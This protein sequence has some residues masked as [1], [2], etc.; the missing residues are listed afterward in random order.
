VLRLAK[1]SVLGVLCT[2]VISAATAGGADKP[3][4]PPTPAPP[5]KADL[6]GDKLFEDLES[7]L[8]TMADS[9]SLRVIVLLRQ[10][11][12][13]GAVD[14]L[15][16]SVGSFSLRHRYSIVPGFAATATKA[17]VEKLAR[18]PIV[19]QVEEDSIVAANN[20]SAQSSFGVTKARIDAGVTGDGDGTPSV[21]SKD[22]FVAAV[23]DTGIDQA[24]RDLDAGKVIGWNDLVNGLPTPYDDNG[25]GTHVA[26]TIAGSGDARGDL[27]YRGAAY[28]GALVGVKVLNASGNGLM[29]DVTAGINW[30]VTNKATYGIEAINLSLSASGC[31]NG[32]DSTSLA[33]NNAFAAGIVVAV[34]AGNSG[35]G[36]CTIGSPGAAANALTV[37][38]M[39]DTGTGAAADTG[40]NGFYQASFSSRGKTLD[41]RIKPDV[42]G[43]GVNV[44]SVEA[45]TAAGYVAFNGTSMATPFVAGVALLM[46][47]ANPALTPAQVKSTIMSTAVDWARGDDNKTQGTTGQDIDYGA[48]RL[49]GYRAIE[50]AKG[51]DIGA[52]P[53]APVHE[54]TEGT[55]GGTG[56]FVDYSLNVTSTQFPIAATLIHPSI[57]GGSAATPDFD[58]RL[59]DPSN[60]QVATALTSLRQD[61][62][63]YKPTVTGTFRLRVE[64]FSGSA[65]FILDISGPFGAGGG[66]LTPPTVTSVSP[67]EGATNVPRST[68]VSVV[69][70]EA[71][72]Q[73]ATQG[74]FSLQDPSSSSVAGAFSWNGDTLTFDPSSDLAQSTVY[75]ARV[76]TGAMDLAGNTLQSDKVWTFTTAAA[77]T[78]VTDNVDVVF[79]DKG[80]PLGG[81]ADLVANDN[82]FYLVKGTATQPRETQWRGQFSNVPAGITNLRLT[83]RDKSSPASTRTVE[84]FNATSGIWVVLDQRSLGTAEV[85]LVLTPPG[86]ASDYVDASGLMIVR[87]RTTRSGSLHR[88]RTDQL[89]ALY[90][91]P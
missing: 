10:A 17:Q 22:D 74:A 19:A 35:P 2:L 82:V 7:K 34:A 75:T 42:S 18:L 21:Y 77:T 9:D 13:A 64:S 65:G 6:D 32:S 86:P 88:H 81:P 52:P 55:L 91:T 59:F 25:H 14:A 58:M 73:A 24:H 54:F 63:G 37:G 45:G 84:I 43:P 26:G 53:D 78:A 48:G 66:D 39:A 33:V 90:D 76:T 11:A 5:T 47:D 44:K 69:F 20:A 51:I 28:D 83:V 16:G 49:D 23:I 50:D 62:L 27:L 4:P 46:L 29:S 38:A 41:G 89:Q 3:A 61:Q 85:A 30:V 79:A 87:L 36:T 57:N 8:A 67:V 71:M 31:S 60:V 12:T 1:A 80:A 68:N 40:P 72:N 56:Q 15:R 70:S